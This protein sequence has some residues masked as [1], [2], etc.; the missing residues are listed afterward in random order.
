[1]NNYANFLSICDDDHEQAMDTLVESLNTTMKIG[2]GKLNR[3]SADTL[4]IM[5]QLYLRRTATSSDER[6][7]DAKRAEVCFVRALHL[8]R[9]ASMSNGDQRI[10]ETLY[11]LMNARQSQLGKG[12]GILR[13]VRFEAEPAIQR[14]YTAYD[15]Y[16]D[17]ELASIVSDINMT[18]GDFAMNL[19]GIPTCGEAGSRESWGSQSSEEDDDDYDVRVPPK[20]VEVAKKVPKRSGSDDEIDK[21]VE[22]KYSPVTLREGKLENNK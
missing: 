14:Q 1:L 22:D 2:G 3:Y 8:Y 17:D 19:F 9:L 12:T 20:N 10:T 11:N 5:G 13:N 21:H 6:M 4:S 16:E 15:I 18:F 7:K